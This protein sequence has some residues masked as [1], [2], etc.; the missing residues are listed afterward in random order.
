MLSDTREYDRGELYTRRATDLVECR[1]DAL[2]P[3]SSDVALGVGEQTGAV[4]REDIRYELGRIDL[5][6]GPKTE[7]KEANEG[8]QEEM[9]ERSIHPVAHSRLSG[10]YFSVEKSTVGATS[11]PA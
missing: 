7:W 2:S 3:L 9:S 4:G 8:E 1:I 6:L 10:D 11:L 5:P